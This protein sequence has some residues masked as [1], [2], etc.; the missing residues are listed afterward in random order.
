[1]E[2][3]PIKVRSGFKKWITPLVRNQV[4]SRLPRLTTADGSTSRRVNHSLLNFL[5]ECRKPETRLLSSS[6]PISSRKSKAEVDI[7]NSE[8][9]DNVS[10]RDS[11]DSE[12]VE[13]II[14]ETRPLARFK[15]AI[16]HCIYYFKTTEEETIRYLEAKIINICDDGDVEDSF[17]RTTKDKGKLF[18]FPHSADE[19]SASVNDIVC[20]L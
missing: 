16:L 2:N 13:L 15:V 12:E 8:S 3:R 18:H 9:N 14:N 17:L 5:Q 1:M 20:K 7:D 4:L 19:A 10:L 11:T 6:A